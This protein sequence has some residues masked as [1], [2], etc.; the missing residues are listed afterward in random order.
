[1]GHYTRKGRY[2]FSSFMQFFF[3]FSVCLTVTLENTT[4]PHTGVQCT[5]DVLLNQNRLRWILQFQNS[6]L[7]DRELHSVLCIS[8]DR[9]IRI[10]HSRMSSVADNSFPLEEAILSG[11]SGQASDNNTVT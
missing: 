7:S 8:P 9:L 4:Q 5:P 1:M 11:A 6:F 10:P 3:W 2:F